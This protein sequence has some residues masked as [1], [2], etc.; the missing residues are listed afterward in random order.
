M[1]TIYSG[2]ID[3]TK[4]IKEK[5]VT[6]NKNGEPF[7]NGAK[8]LNIQII[9]NDDADQYGNH[10]SVSINQTKEERD[11]K[12]PRIFLGNGKKVWES[13]KEN[14]DP[15]KDTTPFLDKDDLPF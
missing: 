10:L 2:S 8:Y 5:L 4:I 12:E 6:T 11:S 7:S 13:P 15:I 14:T 3:V 1:A 9:V